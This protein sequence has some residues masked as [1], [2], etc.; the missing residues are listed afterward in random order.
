MAVRAQ[1]DQIKLRKL[2]S[3]CV[4]STT[5]EPITFMVIKKPIEK[6]PLVVTQCLFQYQ[7]STS[8]YAHLHPEV[9]IILQFCVAIAM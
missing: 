7:F 6:L 9:A 2:N 4:E 3:E 8:D 5:N 1:M